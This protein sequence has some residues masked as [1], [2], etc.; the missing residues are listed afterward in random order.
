MSYLTGN[1]EVLSP[2]STPFRIC[3]THDS[4]N[5]P[6]GY[7]I[8]WASAISGAAG[9]G[10]LINRIA[11]EKNARLVFSGDNSGYLGNIT[12]EGTNLV[13]EI[14]KASSLGGTPAMFN[15][16]A[17]V[18]DKQATFEC[19]AVS[20]TLSSSANRGIA[21]KAGGAKI[22]VAGGRRLCVEWPVDILFMLMTVC[23]AA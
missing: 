1:I 7:E 13:F 16:E 22:N 6:S 23:T 4:A 20:E 15:P 8:T 5:S 2:A 18:L 11:P 9:T 3:P 14:A 10:L 19:S 17:L 12:V 21:V